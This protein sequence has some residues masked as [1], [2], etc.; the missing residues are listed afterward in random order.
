[1][2]KVLSLAVVFLIGA[3]FLMGCASI[4]SKSEYPVVISSQ[5]EGADIT[6]SNSEGKAI[7]SGKTPTTVTLDAKAGFFKGENYT[8]EFK[9]NGCAP[10]SAN[11]TRSVDGWYFV[12]FL[13]GGVIGLFIVDPAT[14]AMWTLKDLH[15]DLA[16]SDVSSTDS[17]LKIVALNEVP[18]HLRPQMI[19]I[20]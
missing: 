15:V 14:G 11:I 19:R 5:P 4:I 18:D 10:H 7:Y 2:K 8:V 20:K 17:T 3:S 12:N 16:S 6:I 9:Q 13:F 1:M